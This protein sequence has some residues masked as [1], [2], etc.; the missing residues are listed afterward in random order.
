MSKKILLLIFLVSLIGS[1]KK[2]N[3][4]GKVYLYRERNYVLNIMQ[5]ELAIWG[6]F[7]S[8]G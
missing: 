6:E 1:S 2:E 7:L 5:R 3:S 8:T 4:I